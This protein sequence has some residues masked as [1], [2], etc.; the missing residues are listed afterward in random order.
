M[1]PFQWVFKNAALSRKLQLS[2]KNLPSRS[3]ETSNS[4]AFSR[5]RLRTLTM[6]SLML[7]SRLHPMEQPH[8]YHP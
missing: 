2:H 8:E 4:F 1:F 3:F 5:P 6:T 7:P